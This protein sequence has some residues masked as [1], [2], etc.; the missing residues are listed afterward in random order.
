MIQFETGGPLTHPFFFAFSGTM[1][2]PRFWSKRWDF[3]TDPLP[4]IRFDWRAR[5]RRV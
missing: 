3:Q 4:A 2:L 5:N 1:K